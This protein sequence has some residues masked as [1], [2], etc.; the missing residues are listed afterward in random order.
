[1]LRL[2]W[3]RH[4]RRWAIAPRVIRHIK[5]FGRRRRRRPGYF[6]VEGKLECFSKIISHY[7]LL[8]FDTYRYGALSTRLIVSPVLAS[9]VRT[10]PRAAAL[11][12]GAV[13]IGYRH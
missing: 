8:C 7:A 1:Y 3:R 12:P 2:D 11:C 6:R 13:Q 10:P 9:P 4:N 5:H